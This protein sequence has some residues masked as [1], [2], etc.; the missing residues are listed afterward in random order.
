MRIIAG[1]WGGRRLVTPKHDR[2]RPT[3]DRVKESL[4]SILGH[5]DGARVLD[6]YAGSGALGLEA[7]SRGAAQ[8]DLVD[9]DFAAIA[10]IRRNL[11]D[12]G[13]SARVHRGDVLRLL[14]RGALQGP[15]DLVFVDPPYERR[16][17]HPTLSAL[18]SSGVL[19]DSAR[20]VNE[21]PRSVVLSDRE[22][23]FSRRLRIETQR[24]YGDV[25]ITVF[26]TAG[27]ER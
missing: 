12:L 25:A 8:L 2:T 16:L 23:P 22:S 4:F 14:Q 17:W 3:A 27:E 26:V 10:A 18:D 21:H 9:R 11:D 7:L 13:A 6:A 1:R 24:S 20:I 15:Y 5:L 19:S